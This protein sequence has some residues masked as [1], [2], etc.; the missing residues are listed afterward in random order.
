MGGGASEV[1]PPTKRRDGNSFSHPE[2][3]GGGTK[4]FGV[5]L[6]QVHKRFPPFKSGGGRGRLKG[7]T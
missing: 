5:V 7:C 3:G 4:D 6:I 1:L 2:W